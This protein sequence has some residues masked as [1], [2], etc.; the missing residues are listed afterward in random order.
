MESIEK[1]IAGDLIAIEDLTSLKK[2]SE[3]FSQGADESLNRKLNRFQEHVER[4]FIL[5][6]YLARKI[7]H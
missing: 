3:R 5:K 1:L 4:T 2:V 7:V 6:K